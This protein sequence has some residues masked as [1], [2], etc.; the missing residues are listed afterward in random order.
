MPRIPRRFS[1]LA[2]I[3]LLSL[4]SAC[5]NSVSITGDVL[6]GSYTATSFVVTQTGQPPVDV[7]SK[8][9]SLT[10]NIA[11]DSTTTGTL[12][13][14]AGAIPGQAGTADMKGKMIRRPDGTYQ[15]DL[16]ESAFIESLV[17]QQFTD[18]LVSTSFLVNTQFQV[19][20]R[21]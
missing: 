19:T 5:E 2:L 1:L 4:A 14:P 13:L 16:T 10:I 9:G 17:W 3:P 18:A 20:I 12:V 15:I 11:A 6:A 21:K 8:G 7:L